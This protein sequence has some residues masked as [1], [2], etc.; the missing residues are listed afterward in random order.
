MRAD[1]TLV[2]LDAD[3]DPDGWRAARVSLGAL[4]VVTALTMQTVPA[5][6]LHGVDGPAPL[7]RTLEQLDEL[8]E[9]HDHFEMYW[10]PY[11]DTALLRSQRPDRRAADR[12]LGVRA[13]RGGHSCWSTTGSARSHGSDA[14]SRR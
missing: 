8:P 3:N 12:A 7:E 1:G 11:T 14:A 10:F 5:F 13:V 6:R 4:G 2:T 9:Q